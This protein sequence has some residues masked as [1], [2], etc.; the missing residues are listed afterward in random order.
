MSFSPGERER[1]EAA[2]TASGTERFARYGLSKTTIAELA[3]DAGISTG[4]FYSFFDSKE[5][6]YLA[7]LEREADSLL[8]ELEPAFEADDAETAIRTLLELSAD[9]LE[10]NPLARSVVEGEEYDRIVGAMTDAE[11]ER[12]RD[13]D[14]GY[15]RPLID[16]HGEAF[17]DLDPAVVTDAIRAAGFVVFHEEEF[18]ENYEAA[19]DLLFASVARGLVRE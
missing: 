13:E 19:R 12:Y 5:R 10:S 8:T 3:D 9:V 17:S 7:V 14:R 6:L 18:G 15:V 1:I 4:S 2:L 11:R 16:E